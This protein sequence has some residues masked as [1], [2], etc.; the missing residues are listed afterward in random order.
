MLTL[1]E[2]KFLNQSSDD[3]NFASDQDPEKIEYEMI[4]IMVN[5]NG[6][7]LAANQIGLNKRIFVMGS[8]KAAGFPLP[9][10]LFNPRIIETSQEE[11][12]DYEGCLSFPGIYLNVK[13]P[14]WIITEFQNSKG[15]IIEARIDGYMSKCFQHELDHLNGV[16]FV[17]K[18][19]KLK[20]QLA[21]KKMRKNKN[22]RT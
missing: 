2:R 6:I 16:C 7:G 15:D 3:W 21:M 18:V 19:S 20:L 4:R 5:N 10:A 9:F 12:L 13:R 14:S 8:E 22:D 17:D 11:I 1:N